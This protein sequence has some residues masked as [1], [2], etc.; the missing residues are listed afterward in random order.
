MSFIGV[1]IGSQSTKTCIIDGEGKV[2][3]SSSFF[4]EISYPYPGWAEE[5]ANLWWKGVKETI[6][7]VLKKVPSKNV[8]AIAF[9]GQSPTMLP[10]DK[11]GKPL[12]PAIIWCDSRSKE[13][14]KIVKE[15][16][17]ERKVFDISGN[18]IDPYFGGNKFFWLKRNRPEVYAQTWKVCQSHGY[19]IFK[20]TD[21]IVTDY[22]V[23]G[24]CS[25][26]YDCRK[27]KWSDEICNELNLDIDMLP[28][29]MPSSAVVGEVTHNAAEE[30][31]LK[32]GT[33]VIVG[34][35]DFAAS[36]L[37]VGAVGEGDASIMLGTA[38]NFIIPMSTQKFDVRLLNT[39]HVVRDNYLVIGSSHGGLILRWMRDQILDTEYNSL[40]DSGMSFYEFMD[41]K[42]SDI[43]IGS[44][45]LILFPYFVGGLTP[46]W[47]PSARGIYFGLTPN[48][49]KAH[50]YRAVLEAVGYSFRYTAS[51]VSERGVHPKMIYS[52]NGGARSAVWRQILSDILNIPV[53][54]VKDNMGAPVGDVIL[55]GVGIGHFRDETVVKDWVKISEINYPD[56]V[57]HEKYKKYY[58][59]YMELY[60]RVKD[61]FALL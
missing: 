43:P 30:T 20:L 17:G 49:N 60:E 33:P 41:N 3:A 26:I 32:K 50:L 40:K 42:S 19:P 36:T 24:L 16:I 18:R 21:R 57:R 47:N 4:Y 39:S 6:K 25:P 56:K 14:C 44:E 8:E 22:S 55:A 29:I 58:H 52:V 31:G 45:G 46:I 51:I 2:L 34:G 54:Y 59:I 61:L 23:A 12:M 48:H 35:G 38:C 15:K 9:S 11:K 13:E 28:E 5:D 7:E 37:S 53:A 27:K 1:D 10:L